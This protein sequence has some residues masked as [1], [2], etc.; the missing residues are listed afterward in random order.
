M[1]VNGTYFKE[2][3]TV[4]IVVHQVMLNSWTGCADVYTQRIMINFTAPA[5]IERS[6]DC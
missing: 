5:D 2:E 3:L 4:L 6:C 1:W